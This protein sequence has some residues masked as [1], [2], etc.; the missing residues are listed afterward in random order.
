MHALTQLEGVDLVVSAGF[1]RGRELQ[2]RLHVVIARDEGFV[3]VHRDVAH[4]H[5][6]VGHHVEAGD[7]GFQPIGE[8]AAGA[9]AF[10]RLGRV[11][12]ERKSCRACQEQG[13]EH[14]VAD[15]HWML[16]GV[17]ITG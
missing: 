1:H 12:D 6:T 9:A 10:E 5:G 15:R 8:V 2:Q 13:A 14:G 16:P 17:W 7:V 11:G 4:R 3:G